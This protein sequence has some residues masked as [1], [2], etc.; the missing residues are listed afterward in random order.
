MP[1]IEANQDGYLAAYDQLPELTQT[2]LL[3]IVQRFWEKSDVFAQDGTRFRVEPESPIKPPTTMEKV[4]ASTLNP[5]R[6][7]A[8]KH[9]SNGTYRIEELKTRIE[10]CVKKDDDILTQFMERSKI[11]EL[12]A[13][14]NSFEEI[15]ALVKKMGEEQPLNDAPD[16]ASLD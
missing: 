12:L 7:I 16:G 10:E 5:M 4:L 2:N 14:A 1:Y 11:L 8:F 13:N 3:A 15:F 6:R 9:V